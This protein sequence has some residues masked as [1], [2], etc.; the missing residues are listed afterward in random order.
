MAK[1][2]DEKKKAKAIAPM[3][4]AE[5]ERCSEQLQKLKAKRRMIVAD[6]NAASIGLGHKRK[7]PSKTKAAVLGSLIYKAAPLTEV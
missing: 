1:A 3:S 2:I 4:S 7:K 5:W 6:P